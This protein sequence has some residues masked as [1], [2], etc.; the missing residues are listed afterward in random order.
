[1]SEE[2][3]LNPR[4]EIYYPNKKNRFG[5]GKTIYTFSMIALITIIVLV[6]MSLLGVI[7]ITFT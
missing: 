2:E 3:K 6:G 4:K 5:F 1:M 7:L